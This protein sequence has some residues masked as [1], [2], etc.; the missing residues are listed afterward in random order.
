[1]P[2]Y[3]RDLPSTKQCLVDFPHRLLDSLLSSS[4]LFHKRT[5]ILCSRS[6]SI[7]LCNMTEAYNIS[8]AVAAWVMPILAL[9]FSVI[10]FIQWHYNVQL[11][12]Q[13]FPMF[14]K[15]DKLAPR[16]MSVFR[17]RLYLADCIR[18]RQ[19]LDLVEV[20]RA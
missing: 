14:P 9:T 18:L 12:V 3:N 7:E 10:A 20:P 15:L 2:S 13:M 8:N 1:M 5:F 6:V 11:N 17:I 4:P 16:T 19:T